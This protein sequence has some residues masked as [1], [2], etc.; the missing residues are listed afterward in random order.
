MFTRY[1]VDENGTLSAT[2]ISQM[3][4]ELKIHVSK[5]DVTRMVE[6]ADSDGDGQVDFKEFC[7][8]IDLASDESDWGK[9]GRNGQLILMGEID[10]VKSMQKTILAVLLV[11]IVLVLYV[12][13]A[14]TA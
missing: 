11:G 3:L 7:T 4:T 2:E 13:H 1:D 8:V 9:V 10:E 12:F 6:E 5:A 14:K